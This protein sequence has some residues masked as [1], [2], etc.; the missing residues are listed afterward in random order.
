MSLIQAQQQLVE[1]KQR[2]AEAAEVF[3]KALDKADAET[4]TLQRRVQQL[5][6]ELKQ[7]LDVG[8]ASNPSAPSARP[9]KKKSAKKDLSVMAHLGNLQ[10]TDVLTVAA[11]ATGGGGE[12]EQQR[13]ALAKAERELQVLH[14]ENVQLKE[15]IAALTEELHNAHDDL[16]LATSDVDKQTV[17]LREQIR[18][19]ELQLKN[20][21]SGAQAAE[22]RLRSLGEEN[23]RLQAELESLAHSLQTP[24][25]ATN[26]A[27]QRLKEE[28]RALAK[29]L[30]PT[31]NKLVEYMAMA[32]RLGIQYPFSADMEGT[33]V[34]RLKA[35]HF[36]TRTGRVRASSAPRQLYAS[37]GRHGP[38]AAKKTTT[39][40]GEKK[41]RRK[42]REGQFEDGDDLR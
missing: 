7:S 23:R 25:E 9:K 19:L 2:T 26:V 28:L 31:K 3:G 27:V 18:F 38:P 24:T 16:E 1:E 11:V 40:P 15:R 37:D 21:P 41:K 22:A 29:E 4:A 34:V 42:R 33:A 17:G 39:T 36:D 13:S 35:M 30:V 12:A 8:N 20:S 5:E 32:D 14:Q 10:E 6:D